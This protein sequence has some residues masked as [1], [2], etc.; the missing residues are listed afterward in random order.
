[1]CS[2]LAATQDAHRETG[3]HTRR[4]IPAP[5]TPFPSAAVPADHIVSHASFASLHPHFF[6]TVTAKQHEAAATPRVLMHANDRSA[7][8]IRLSAKRPSATAKLA[9]EIHEPA[10]PS[11]EAARAGA[12]SGSTTRGSRAS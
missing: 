2:R 10:P 6:A 4:H 3:T 11:P 8:A 1:M 9:A 7:K 12:S 5:A